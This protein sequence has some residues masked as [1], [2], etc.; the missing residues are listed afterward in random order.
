MKEEIEKKIGYSFQDSAL[1]E[2]AFTHRS[3][4]NEH[5]NSCLG[6]NERLEFLGDSILGLLVAEYLYTSLPD[7][8]E[9]SCSK[10]RAQLVAASACAEHVK[11][12]EIDSYL[13]LGKGE[14][15]NQGKGRD[16]ILADLFE[17]LLGAIY[18]DGGYQV[19][20]SF[21]FDNFLEAIQS[22]QAAPERNWKADLQDYTQ[23]HFQLTPAYEVLEEFGPSHKKE[24]RVAVLMGNEKIGEGCGLS[25]KEAQKEAAKAAL[26][27]IER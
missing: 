21:F 15:F 22:Q 8:S 5:Q 19:A 2:L 17:A 3:F 6:H 7:A 4:W 24:F 23:K 18:L 11:A 9:G 20:R 13:R 10:I 27:E 25:K 26:L 14:Q 16:S 1:L 12:L